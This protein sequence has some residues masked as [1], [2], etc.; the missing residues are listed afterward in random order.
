MK[1]FLSDVQKIRDRARSA[2]SEGA[3]TSGLKTEREQVIKVLNEVLA[4]ELVCTLRYKHHYYMAK[5]IHSESVREEFLEHAREEQEHADWVAERIVQL[6]GKPDFN[7]VVLAERSHSEYVEGGDLVTMIEEDLVAER[8]AIETYL[9]IVRWLGN[10]DPTTR[11]LIE[12]ILAKEEEHA[13]D[14][15][16]LLED[17]PHREQVPG[18][19]DGGGKSGKRTTS[20]MANDAQP[21]T[22]D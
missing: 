4:T 9:E 20:R 17:I 2:I 14:L 16:T 5:G 18:A 1:P 3:V 15:S 21:L 11:G 7:P 10:E 6:N 22:G 12:R 19:K 13:E 8:I